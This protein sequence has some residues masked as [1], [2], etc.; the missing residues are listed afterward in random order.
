MH[1]GTF[2]NDNGIIELVVLLRVKTLVNVITTLTDAEEVQFDAQLNLTTYS[3]TKA[4][5]KDDV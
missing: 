4:S 5:T 1:C 2:A 3:S